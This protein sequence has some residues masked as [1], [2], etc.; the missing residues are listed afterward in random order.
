[1]PNEG[2][3]AG[4]PKKRIRVFWGPRSRPY[5]N[6]QRSA[7]PLGL[8]YGLLIPVAPTRNPAHDRSQLGA[9]FCVNARI[10]SC[11]SSVVAMLQ[12]ISAA[13]PIVRR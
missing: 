7:G 11:A 12:K 4:H 13:S 6:H 5:K 9:R 1:M 2:G 10:P 8:E 3:F